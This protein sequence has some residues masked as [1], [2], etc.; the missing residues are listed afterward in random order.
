[1]LPLSLEPPDLTI[2]KDAFPIAVVDTLTE[3]GQRPERNLGSIAATGMEILLWRISPAIFTHTTQ[4]QY[5]LSA[6]SSHF[7]S[8]IALDD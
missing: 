6:I 5:Y 1:M 3:R 8:V 2:S 7:S 4:Q